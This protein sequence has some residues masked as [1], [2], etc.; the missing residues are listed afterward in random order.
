MSHGPHLFRKRDFV[1]SVEAVMAAGDADRFRRA[2]LERGKR[3][4][5]NAAALKAAW[6]DIDQAEHE[7]E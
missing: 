2:R 1:K 7:L 6:L 5:G 3:N 4:G